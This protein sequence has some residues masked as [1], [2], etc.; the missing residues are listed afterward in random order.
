[1]L[2]ICDIQTSQRHLGQKNAS[3]APGEQMY[4]AAGFCAIRGITAYQKPVVPIQQS[5]P[6]EVAKEQE[7]FLS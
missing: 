1:V 7:I 6:E 2:T 4:Q 3:V 5:A